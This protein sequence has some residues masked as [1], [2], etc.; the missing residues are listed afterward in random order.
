[1][2]K[3]I[4]IESYSI[5]A[6]KSYLL[7]QIKLKYP[8]AVIIPEPI[9]KWES[10][11]NED[12]ENLL[13]LFYKFTNK[14][15]F[16]F[17]LSALLSRFS[18]L[19]QTIKDNPN[20]E[21][22][23]TERCLLTDKYVFMQMLYDSGDICKIEYELYNDY[24][25]MVISKTIPISGIINVNTNLDLSMERIKLRNRAGEDKITSNYLEN[26]RKYQENWFNNLDTNIK[27]ISLTSD[28]IDKTIEFINTV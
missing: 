11:I 20:T 1:M 13:Q 4:S 10:Y 12:G 5:G 15:A 22:F 6:G 8:N 25:N 9:K 19:D 26:L 17:Q 14:Y 3:L 28:D 16:T 7:E 18:L 2:V 27:F 24:F 23:I 21:I